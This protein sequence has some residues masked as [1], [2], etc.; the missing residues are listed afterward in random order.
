M[1]T[2][3]PEGVLGSPRYPW[4]LDSPGLLSPTTVDCGTIQNPAGEFYI[5][6]FK[7]KDGTDRILGT[8][9]EGVK[10]LG[11][12]SGKW[13][14]HPQPGT[15]IAHHYFNDREGRPRGGVLFFAPTAPRLITF[16]FSCFPSD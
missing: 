11:Y 2:P 9:L 5:T 3:E 10:L 7:V 6:V 15:Q 12:C 14:A 16:T 1:Q 4:V 13:Q 8:C